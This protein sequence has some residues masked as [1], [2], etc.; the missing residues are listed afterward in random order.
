MMSRL[1]TELAE[2]KRRY[3]QYQANAKPTDSQKW[4]REIAALEQEKNQLNANFQTLLTMN[5]S[6]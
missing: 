2:S 3:Q 5:A 4:H 1:E 6:L